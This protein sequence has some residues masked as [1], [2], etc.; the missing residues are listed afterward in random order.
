MQIFIKFHRDNNEHLQ[1]FT[2]EVEN[3]DTIE[4]VKEKIT[5]IITTPV[6]DQ[7][8]YFHGVELEDGRTLKDYNIQKEGDLDL[9]IK[10]VTSTT[11]LIVPIAISAVSFSLL[12]SIIV[13]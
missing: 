7:I 6:K 3:A 8:L 1:I 13:W 2:L 4:S 12:C 5:L 11:S 10:A 9:F